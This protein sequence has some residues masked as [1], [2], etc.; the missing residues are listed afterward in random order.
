MRLKI[1]HRTEYHYDQPNIY[2]LQRLRLVPQ[3]NDKQRVSNWSVQIDGGVEEANYTDGFGNATRLVSVLPGQTDISAT[4][5]GTIETTDGSGITGPHRGYAPLWLFLQPTPL[6]EPGPA[7]RALAADIKEGAPLDRLH[8]LM[9]SIVSRVTYEKGTTAVGTLAEEA[10]AK[11]S[12]V[13][14]DQAHIFASASRLLGLPAR[15][16]SGYLLLKEHGEAASH[17]W[18][19]SHVPGLGWVAFDCANGISPD[20]H[21][22]RLA[23][24]RDYRDAAPVSGFRLGGA[25]ERLEVHLTVEQ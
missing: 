2:A 17:A 11:G 8:E 24:G 16:V 1:T 15:Y 5:T 12:G 13:C 20:E 6:T 18:A 7:I 14:Q 10:A 9:Q 3:S 23:I 19:E 25:A 4:A 21:Y 22:A